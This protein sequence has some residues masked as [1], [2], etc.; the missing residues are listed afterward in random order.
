MLLKHLKETFSLGLELS[1][2]SGDLLDDL[3]IGELFEPI[4][5]MAALLVLSH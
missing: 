5:D 4:V 3:G 1:G 2:T